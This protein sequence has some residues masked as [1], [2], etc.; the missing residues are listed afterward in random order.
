MNTY[1]AMFLF[2]TTFSADFSK[3][4]QEVGRMMQR[5]GAEIVM[6]R[7]WDERK[8]A[9]EIKGQRRGC[10]VLAFFR[11]D[12]GSIARIE[13]DAQL[14]EPVLRLLILRADHMTTQDMEAA[15]PSRPAAAAE[16]GGAGAEEAPAEKTSQEA[17]TAAKRELPTALQTGVSSEAP[18][19]KTPEEL[20][21]AAQVPDATPDTPA[22]IE[23]AE[24]DRLDKTDWNPD[25]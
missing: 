3:V 22:A 5:A 14:S 7:K 25:P 19:G 10:Y 17:F 20:A 13:R 8:L 11:A 23:P 2:D 21:S 18:A 9:Y 24:A 12:P 1:E 4:E 15:Y 16:R 6:C